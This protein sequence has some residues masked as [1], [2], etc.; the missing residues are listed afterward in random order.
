MAVA[1]IKYNAGNVRSVLY[2]L[3]RLGAAAFVTADENEIRNADH[4]IFP[5]VGEAASAMQHLRETGLDKLIPSLTQPVLGICLGMQLLC[6]HSEEGN[7]EALGIFPLQVK[8]FV[9][10]TGD[11]AFKIPQMGWNTITKLDPLLFAG[12]TENSYMYF[13]HSY[14]VEAGTN[15]AAETNYILPYASALQK[16]NFYAVQFHP[17]KSGKSGEQLLAN[18]LKQR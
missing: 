5:G 12:I 3:D 1:V 4:V 6:T 9:N 11:P 2:A 7:T 14:Y 10:T 8:K 18:F 15:Q 16:R 17:E 13:V